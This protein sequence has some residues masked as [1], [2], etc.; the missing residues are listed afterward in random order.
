M[1]TQTEVEFSLITIT[2]VTHKTCDV[3]CAAIPILLIISSLSRSKS[4]NTHD[5]SK[6][7]QEEVG[8]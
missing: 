2:Q 7:I 4:N 3:I 6:Q 1:S 5:I 8:N